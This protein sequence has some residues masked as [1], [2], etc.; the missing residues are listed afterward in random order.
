MV[1][2]RNRMKLSEMFAFTQDLIESETGSADL[3]KP[4]VILQISADHAG[5]RNENGNF[6]FELFRENA[7]SSEC[8][9]DRAKPIAGC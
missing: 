6:N 8:Q 9:N 7:S 4:D 2:H 1:L 3:N 5:R